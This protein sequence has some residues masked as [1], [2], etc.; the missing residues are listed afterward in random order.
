MKFSTSC[1]ILASSLRFGSKVT[2][3]ALW[4]P[5]PIYSKPF[6]TLAIFSLDLR[7]SFVYVI[8]WRVHRDSFL[9]TGIW[10]L[11]CG[12]K[13]RTYLLVTAFM[14]WWWGAIVFIGASNAVSC[15]ISSFSISSSSWRLRVPGDLLET[16]S[17]V[18]VSTL[19]SG[20]TAESR[21]KMSQFS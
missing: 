5:V 1:T 9:W 20:E 18:F 13:L 11:F 17:L 14:S 21:R 8:S 16:I 7:E 12:R 10:S 15:F 4:W 19:E 6:S 2:W 3:L